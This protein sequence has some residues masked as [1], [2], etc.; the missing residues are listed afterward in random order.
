[1]NKK[2]KKLYYEPRCGFQIVGCLLKKH[3][4]L[5]DMTFDL[6]HG[7]F[8]EEFHKG[9]FTA[10]FNLLQEGIEEITP[11]EIESYLQ[12][13]SPRYYK[14]VFEDNDGFDWMEESIKHASLANF[15][16]N[17]NRLKKMSLLRDFIDNGYDVSEILDLEE[18][19]N[20]I[21]EQQNK[22]FDA[23]TLDDL[24]KTYET[25][26][27][28]IKGKYETNAQ[29]DYKRAG[30]NSEQTIERL[31]AG[32]NYG[33]LGLSGYKN[34]VTYGNRRKKF[35][36]MSSGTGGGKS[37]SALGE[38]ASLI[39]VELWDY[40]KQSFVPNPN[41]PHGE[42]S[43]IYVGTELELDREV[44]IILWA[45]ISGIE[46]SKI[47]EWDLTQEE[48]K[49]LYYAIEIVK[50]S[51]I[52]L[53]DRPNYDI[54]LL[55]N[56]VKKH[57]MTED[58]YML[59]IDYILLTTNLVMEARKYSDGMWTRE[60][61]LFLFISKSF[62]ERLANGLN[63]YV[64]SS[65]QLNRSYNDKTAEKNEGMIRGSFALCDKVD[66]GS[67]VLKIEK[68]ELEFIEQIL[69]KGWNN[70]VPTHVE[71]IFKNRGGKYDKIRIFR[72]VNLGNMLLED[73][74]CTNW[75]YEL[76]DIEQVF[77]ESITEEGIEKNSE[78]LF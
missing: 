69:K 24:F 78:A 43:G 17:Y 18:I 51:K 1:M 31:K 77:A 27:V 14:I 65:T 34:R 70:V 68:Q 64:S 35:H 76:L 6:K 38:L 32:E 10:I 13:I 30:D 7:D 29:G 37:R 33:L 53:Y 40:E 47:I 46:S 2:L 9:I 36:L 49:R 48:E 71:H 23:M 56:I 5:D 25:K 39:S 66:V 3:S 41:N 20:K 72:T 42:L 50:K 57:Q 58:V 61:Q 15:E 45:V 21:I 12:R 54:A 73:L 22:A 74:F 60:D 44:D 62:K 63:I 28:N 75:D 67:L 4:L 16:H 11:I 8:Y 19:D 52:H 55:E 26:M 59:G